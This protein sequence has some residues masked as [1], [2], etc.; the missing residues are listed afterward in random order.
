MSFAQSVSLI[1]IIAIGLLIVMEMGLAWLSKRPA[2]G[3]ADTVAN[4]GLILLYLS[5]KGLYTAV[6]GSGLRDCLYI[7]TKLRR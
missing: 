3:L 1:A 5:T 7:F 2:Y 6:T 4:V